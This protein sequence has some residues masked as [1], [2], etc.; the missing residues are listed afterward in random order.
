MHD[1]HEVRIST[2]DAA[3]MGG[4]S[5]GT[6]YRRRREMDVLKERQIGVAEGLPCAEWAV[7]VL[8]I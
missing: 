3:R 1:W 2:A 4:M 6:F 5:E 7:T 8:A